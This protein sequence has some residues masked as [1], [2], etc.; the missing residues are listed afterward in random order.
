MSLSAADRELLEASVPGPAATVA[1]HE[2]LGC[3]VWSDEV[4]PGLSPAGQDY[5]RDLLGARGYIHRGTPVEAWDFGATDRLERWN[6]ALR[7]GLR[8]MGFQRLLLGPEHRALLERR[9]ADES[10][11]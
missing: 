1:F 3:L 4:P 10:D 5:V 11:L 2:I 8:W 9:L 7:T 6:E